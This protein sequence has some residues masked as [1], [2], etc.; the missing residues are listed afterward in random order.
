M[1]TKNKIAVCI[2]F[3][4]KVEQ[5]IECISSAITNQVN[6]YVLNNNST[7]AA[8][9]LIKAKFKDFDN[10]IFFESPINLGPAKGRNFLIENCSE[11]WLFFLDNDIVIK[12]K[13]WYQHAIN[14]TETHKDV[15]VFI[16]KLFNVHENSWANF[17]EYKLVDN[18]IQGNIAKAKQTNCFPGG[19]SIVNK[20]LFLR[21]GNY[22]NNIT[23]LE[24]YEFSIRGIMTSFP[25]NALLIH[26]IELIHTHKYSKIKSDIKATKIRYAKEQYTLAEK[27]IEQKYNVVFNS[28]WSIWVHAQLELMVYKSVFKKIKNYLL[29]YRNRIKKLL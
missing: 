1:E 7:V 4:E 29:I 14:F 21:L 6:V 10:V 3:F 13:N 22:S 2:I 20:S 12:T 17:H 15:E 26:N 16:P 11:Q 23:V 25:I 28:G 24:D 27:Y 19:A 5:T 8:T 18:L 9:I